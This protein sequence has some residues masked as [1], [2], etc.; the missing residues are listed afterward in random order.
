MS[1]E[2][3]HAL[4]ANTPDSRPVALQAGACK[5]S[6]AV[7]GRLSATTCAHL[8]ETTFSFP[9]ERILSIRTGFN[10]EGLTAGV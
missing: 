10:F 9:R 7:R 6:V 4:L 2:A 8:S 3:P 5:E 1:R